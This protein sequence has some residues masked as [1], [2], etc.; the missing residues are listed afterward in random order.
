MEGRLLLDTDVL[1]EY[2]RG[3]REAADYLEGLTA[4]LYVSVVTI[5]ELF[6]G[7]RGEDE[8]RSLEGF[9][10]AF[11]ALPVTERVAR[12]G[13]LYRRDYGPSD[14]TGLADALIA[15]TAEE[16]GLG[17]VTFNRRHFP[18]VSRVA[19]PYER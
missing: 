11:T 9:L 10:L 18:M 14:G 12:L 6:V 15:A 1:V 16:N 4:D 3:R 5:A 8:E 2:L 13:G 17:L 19:T 7:V